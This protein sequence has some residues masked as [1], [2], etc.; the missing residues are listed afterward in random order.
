MVILAALG[1]FVFTTRSI[2]FQGLERAQNWKH[3]HQNVV[4]DYPPSQYTGKEPEE[5]SISAEL[6]PEVTGGVY[7]IRDLREMADTGEPHPLILGTGEVLGSFV[8][9]S[10]GEKR[11][12]LNQDG[13]PRAIAFSMGLKKV[14]ETA[15]GMRDKNLLLAAGMVRKITG[16]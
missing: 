7:S 8:I 14:S 1:M 15:V 4:G 10:I 3:P 16:I 11:S 5:I 12:E 13:S 6:R 2:P 9:T